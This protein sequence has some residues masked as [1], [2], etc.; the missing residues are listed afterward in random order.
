MSKMIALSFICSDI[1]SAVECLFH[2][3]HPA[4]SMNF[5]ALSR[6]QGLTSV[7]GNAIKW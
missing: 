4:E 1:F 3:I 2:E 7:L 5:A 6:S